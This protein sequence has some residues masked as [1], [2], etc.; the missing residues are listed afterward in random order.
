MAGGHSSMPPDHT[1]SKQL[2]SFPKSSIILTAVQLAT[3]PK[4]FKKSKRTNFPPA[5]QTRTLPKRSFK[6]PHNMQRP[7][8]RVFETLFGICSDLPTKCDIG[9]HNTQFD[10]NECFLV[11][12]TRLINKELVSPKLCFFKSQKGIGRIKGEIK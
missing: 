12:K 1:A 10:Q 5:S 3:L 7:R 6:E 2:S 11:N 8:I 9:Q 4:S